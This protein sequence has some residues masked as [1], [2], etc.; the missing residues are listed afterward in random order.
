MIV[1]VPIFLQTGLFLTSTSVALFASCQK[2][3]H[4]DSRRS[5][6]TEES[7]IQPSPGSPTEPKVP[8][9][10]QDELSVE[11]FL[12]SKVSVAREQLFKYLELSKKAYIEKSEDYFQSEREVFSTVSSLHDKR[13]QIFPDALYVITGGLFGSVFARKRNIVVKAFAPIVCG[14]ISFRIFFP[15]TYSNVFGFLDKSEKE[16]LPDI[17]AKQTEL[18]NK[19]EELVK[20]SSEAADDSSKQISSFFDNAK[21]TF[22][23][24]TGLKVDQTITNKKK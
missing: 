11:S 8:K 24:Y 14:L 4:C 1:F 6:Y 19:A 16:N 3:I 15:N 9:L 10:V 12:E 21:K 7:Q 2:P 13:E 20:K 5:F 23:E 18:I 17:Y 22:G